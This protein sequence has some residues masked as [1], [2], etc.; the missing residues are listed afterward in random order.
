VAV[1]KEY[2]D[3]VVA[4]VQ[5][6]A[7]VN[8]RSPY[9]EGRNSV[10]HRAARRGNIHMAELLISLSADVHALNADG[11]TFVDLAR[12]CGH[13][14][15]VATFH[16]SLH[17]TD[18]DTVES[19]M[20]C[21]GYALTVQ[22]QGQAIDWWQKIC[23]LPEAYQAVVLRPVEVIGDETITE[24]RRR[25]FKDMRLPTT[26]QQFNRLVLSLENAIENSVFMTMSCH[27]KVLSLLFYEVIYGHNSEMVLVGLGQL[28]ENAPLVW[29]LDI[30]YY[31]TLLLK[32][33]I[34]S[35]FVWDVY[36]WC[37]SVCYFFSGV[38][39]CCLVKSGVAVTFVRDHLGDLLTLLQLLSNAAIDMRP[40]QLMPNSVI[41]TRKY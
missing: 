29:K 3:A 40:D 4:L 6:G 7:S 35:Q 26:G 37:D 32:P 2:E 24:C 33:A 28:A 23:E 20:K 1:D 25:V 9:L 16:A 8:D 30:L 12:Y 14:E 34:S 17:M 5:M 36:A 13:A 21:G 38:H 10:L 22:S 11:L 18:E 19:L 27:L 31:S 39:T 41:D 15:F